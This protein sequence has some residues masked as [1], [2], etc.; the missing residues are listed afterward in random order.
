MAK[1]SLRGKAGA[2]ACALAFM[3]PIA[4]AQESAPPA[5]PLIEEI[6][7]RIEE[8]FYDR[9]AAGRGWRA[10]CDSTARALGPG[11]Q[12]EAVSAAAAGMLASLRAS[13]TARYT[14]DQP[15]YYELL[16]IFARG[17][18][19][20]LRG[21]FP[22]GE[23]AYTGIGLATR[24][25]DGRVFA[26]GV[27]HTGPAERAGVLRGDEIV[28]LDGRPYAGTRGLEGREGQKL[29]MVVRRAA[30]GPPLD[31][32]VVPQRIRPNELFLEAMRG[33]A[34]VIEQDGRRLGYIRVWSY[35]RRSYQELLAEELWRGRLKDA[36]GLVLDLRGGWGGAQPEYAE[37]FVGGVPTM[38]VTNR[39][40]GQNASNFRYRK[41]V[42][43]LIDRG[44]RS[45][46]EILA[47]AFQKNG[48]PLVGQRS[49]GAVLAGQAFML[50]DASLL[51][52]AVLDVHLDG[53]RLEGRG[54]APDVPVEFE[55]PYAA[56]ADPQ[57]AAALGVLS[58]RLREA[59][60]AAKAPEA[61]PTI[62]Q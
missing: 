52:I 37:L 51:I 41:P 38:T 48:I 1:L 13:H 34:R 59:E 16:D 44:S 35:A 26:D 18:G 12:P 43:V 8:R 30:G 40:G 7:R 3:A 39:D 31:L 36:D 22:G 11:A 28:S 33:S 20:R 57:L 25:Q 58:V 10:T 42:V 45:G 6:C 27:Y 29:R 5:Q 47:R 17:L 54:V 24:E 60:R 46:K 55:L 4:A 23:V 53:E 2:L 49:T 50:S 32:E 14:A 62:L 56:G 15:A 19:D 21:M 9:A 61:E